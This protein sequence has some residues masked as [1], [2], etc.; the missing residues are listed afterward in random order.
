MKKKLLFIFAVLTLRGLPQSG[1]IDTLYHL[2]SIHFFPENYR[3]SVHCIIN[4]LSLQL[5]VS[6]WQKVKVYDVL[7]NEIATLVDEYKPARRYEL[8]FSYRGGLS[9][10]ICS[11]PLRVGDY[12]APQ[13]MIRWKWNQTN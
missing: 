6:S 13:K 1:N 10:G 8:E 5:P 12:F 3:T 9:I 7:G 11:F 2:L 4:N